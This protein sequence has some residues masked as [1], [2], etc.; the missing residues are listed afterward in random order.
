MNC[1]YPSCM[2]CQ[3]GEIHKECRMIGLHTVNELELL[4]VKEKCMNLGDKIKLH[5][6]IKQTFSDKPNIVD[7]DFTIIGVKKGLSHCFGDDM[8]SQGFNS[9]EYGEEQDGRPDI[10]LKGSVYVA[11]PSQLDEMVVKDLH[12]DN[13]VVSWEVTAK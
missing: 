6:E 10:V 11:L 13:K 5:I 12:Y 3:C 7:G 4:N 1:D 2:N 9:F 8:H